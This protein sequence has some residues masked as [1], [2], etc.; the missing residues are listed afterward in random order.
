MF[1]NLEAKAEDQILTGITF[2]YSWAALTWVIKEIKLVAWTT[3]IETIKWTDIETLT[4][5]IAFTDLSYNLQKD[6]VTQLTLKVLLEDWEVAS[7]GSKF[8]F[9]L[10]W[11]N[12]LTARNE[13][14]SV[15]TTVNDLTIKW[16]TYTVATDTPTVAFTVDGTKVSVVVSNPSSYAIELTGINFSVLKSIVNSQ[17][18]DWTGIANLLDVADVKVTTQ[19]PAIPSNNVTF[20]GLNS[21]DI[22]SNSSITYILDVEWAGV[23]LTPEYYTTTIKWIEFI[24]T[25]GSNAPSNLIKET[26]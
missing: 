17:I 7:L 5:S 11:A 9:T 20:S 14:D 21:Y 23:Q 13:D 25:D 6:K 26:Y 24:Y 3:T 16:T 8:E 22:A 12:V 2:T 15:T 1:F 10:D 4:T 19:T 18:A